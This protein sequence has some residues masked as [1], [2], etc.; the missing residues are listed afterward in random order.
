MSYRQHRQNLNI[1][2]SLH[3]RVPFICK[4]KPG[5][6]GISSPSDYEERED[7]ED[8]NADSEEISQLGE[9][10]YSL[11]VQ[12]VSDDEIRSTLL[13]KR[14]DSAMVIIIVILAYQWTLFNFPGYRG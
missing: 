10:M 6:P 1:N 3:F 8:Y 14:T 2:N 4:F 7:E 13:E 12:L 5:I 11:K 9:E